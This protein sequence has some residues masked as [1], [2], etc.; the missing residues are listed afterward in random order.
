MT[1]NLW[2][3]LSANANINDSDDV[4]FDKFSAEIISRKRRENDIIGR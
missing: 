2:C 4:L 1:T 3:I